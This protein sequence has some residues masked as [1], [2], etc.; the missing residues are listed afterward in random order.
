MRKQYAIAAIAA[1]WCTACSDQAGA[2]PETTITANNAEAMRIEDSR[3]ALDYVA[4]IVR[5]AHPDTQ[6]GLSEETRLALATASTAV[7]GSM[8]QEQ[9]RFV[10][11]EWLA[12]LH[13]AHVE[14]RYR[15][16]SGVDVGCVDLPLS[17]RPEGLIVTRSSSAL[18]A[19]DRILAIG[20]HDEPG[21]LDQMRRI[22]PTESEYRLK[23]VAAQ[24]LQ[25]GDYLR[26]LG[27]VTD[28]GVKVVAETDGGRERSLLLQ[29]D[30]CPE[31]DLA[32]G[33]VGF[34]IYDEASVGVFWLDRFDYNQEMVD[35]MEAFFS[36]VD[37]REIKSIVVD[38]R[39]KAGGDSTVAFAFLEHF[40][41]ISYESFSVDV[42]ISDELSA[43]IPAFSP[44]AM[45]PVFVEAGMPPIADDARHYVLPGP[46]VRLA[47][48]GRMNL[49]S[50]DEM[51]KVADRDLYMLTDAGTFSSGNLFAILLRDNNIGTLI[52]EPTGNRVNFNGSELAFDIPGTDMYLN[53]STAKMIR[54]DASQGDAPT[55]D[56]DVLIVTSRNDIAIGR[57]PQMEYLLQGA[58]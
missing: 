29:L 3:A 37:K 1:I 51:L 30:S 22:V 50:P 54:P 26:W 31:A 17:W 27:A 36:E 25:H 53:I 55:I 38:L 35:T 40:A 34:D 56:P 42:R 19:G 23:Y 48:A 9:L 8:N 6:A 24:R 41:D 16:D 46:F 28:S 4:D 10:L 5:N 43:A 39:S 14:V 33:W 49:K 57:D 44:S 2:P 13:D 45:S 32:H 7:S 20:E 52:G 58:D 21:L 12:T 18:R 15:D 11:N 47:I